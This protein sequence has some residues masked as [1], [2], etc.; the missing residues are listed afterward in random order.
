MGQ[1]AAS[2]R[3]GLYTW[4]EGSVRGGIWGEKLPRIIS[5]CGQKTRGSYL[6]I[7]G[8]LVRPVI[9]QPPH[10]SIMD[11][12]PLYHPCDPDDVARRTNAHIPQ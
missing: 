1:N 4:D 6:G 9:H 12:T 3:F 7:C 2:H 10:L 11:T 5:G 8:A